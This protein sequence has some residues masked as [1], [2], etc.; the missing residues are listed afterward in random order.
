MKTKNIANKDK[1]K[2]EKNKKHS[3]KRT[4]K[5]KQHPFWKPATKLEPIRRGKPCWLTASTVWGNRRNHN[6]HCLGN[7]VDHETVMMTN[8]RNSSK[9]C[10]EKLYSYTCATCTCIYRYE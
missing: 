8:R 3:K 6:K 5:N 7:N 9:H 10:L 4:H 2:N 1:K